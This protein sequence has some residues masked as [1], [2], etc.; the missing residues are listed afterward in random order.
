MDPQLS[1]NSPQLSCNSAELQTMVLKSMSCTFRGL[2]CTLQ[3]TATQSPALSKKHC[4]TRAIQRNS[5]QLT[6]PRK[7]RKKDAELQSRG[8]CGSPPPGAPPFA[9]YPQ[10]KF[11]KFVLRIPSTSSSFRKL[12]DA[13]RNPSSFLFPVRTSQF[14]IFQLANFLF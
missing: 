12:Q 6:G 10:V 9:N 7:H 4:K 1:C 14:A 13:F 11:K 8:A 5:L 2:S 3:L